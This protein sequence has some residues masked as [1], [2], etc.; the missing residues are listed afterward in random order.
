MDFWKRLKELRAE[1]GLNQ[2]VIAEKLGVSGQSYSAYEN[3]RE[4]PYSAL[5]TIAK[6]FHVTTDYLLG[7][8]DARKPENASIMDKYGL[9][10]VALNTIEQMGAEEKALLEYL[11]INQNVLNP[12]K[13]LIKS[14]QK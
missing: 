3:G 7:L 13:L 8:S 2:S 10:E 9:T 4:P 12:L 6:F 5:C 1:L 14:I 11:L